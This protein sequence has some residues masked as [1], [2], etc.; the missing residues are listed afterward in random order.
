VVKYLQGVQV[1]FVGATLSATPTIVLPS[2][3]AGLTF[4]DEVASINAQV[5]AL[6]ARGVH[7]IVVL[8]HDGVYQAGGYTGPTSATQA[9]PADLVALVARLDADVDVVIT[10]HSH[11]FA[12]EFVK[13]AGGR[14]VLVTQAYSAG[15]AFAN[16]DLTVDGA[17]QDVTAATAAVV[18]TYAT[19]I[20]P[21]PAAAALTA[22][23][24][25]RVAPLTSVQVATASAIVSKTLNAAGE[26]PLGDLLAEAHRTAMGADFGITNPGGMR[27]DL[28]STCIGSPCAITW[29][30]CFSA[31]P[32]ANQVM[33]VTLTGRQL[34]AALE[35]QFA[36]WNGQTQTR[37]LQV[38]GFTYTWSAGA[39]LG[40]RVVGGSLR[41]AD[42]TA[43]DPAASYTVAMNNYLQ[44]GGDG[45][46]VLK[47]G[48]G[49]VTGPIDLDALLSYLRGLGGPVAPT[50]DGR[51]SQVP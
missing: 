23:A 36:G 46:S 6:Q 7:A 48:T 25:Q 13:N 33:R 51:I 43:I 18:T 1:A 40:S 11:N 44:G 26:A 17:S 10:G 8:L 2:G 4:D 28:P 22:A 5:K 9:A 47:A 29:G 34:A 21:D 27:A 30:D 45:F 35:Q 20:T 19:G 14:D 32:F 42:G 49:V 31:Q 37:M 12:N 15:T 50:T 24:E 38:S 41:R 39:A 16:I 3:V